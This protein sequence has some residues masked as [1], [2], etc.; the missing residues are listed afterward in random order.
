MKIYICALTKLK[1][2]RFKTRM[3]AIAIC[4]AFASI[5]FTSCKK[6]NVA[7]KLTAENNS[8]SIASIKQNL[9]AWYKFTNGNTG[10]YSGN[11]NPLNAHHVTLDTD[12]MGRPNN[13]C[14]FNGFSS[15]MQTGNSRSLNPSSITLVALFKPTGFYGG[16]TTRILMKGTDDQSNGDYYLGYQNN[17]AMYGL[18]GDGQFQS[19]NPV[20]PQGT[21]QLNSWYKLVY[22]Y[23]DGVGKLYVN[24]VLVNQAN[25]TASFNHNISPLRIG[26]TGRPDFPYWFNGVIDE[27]RIYNIALSAKQVANVDSQLGK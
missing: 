27:I 10:D 6:D 26:T 25:V 11:N 13:A 23:G 17:G 9:V 20:S 21:L 24:D 1:F 5:Q 7:T 8:N 19:N 18:Y 15:Y 12:Y 3:L 4:F 2:M 22:T 16:I 14:R